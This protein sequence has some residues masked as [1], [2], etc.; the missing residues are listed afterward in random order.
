MVRSRA[1]ILG[2]RPG[3]FTLR[4]RS[5]IGSVHAR[6]GTAVAVLLLVPVVVAAAFTSPKAGATSAPVKGAQCFT[7]DGTSENG[8]TRTGSNP[9]RFKFR[10]TPYVGVRWDRCGAL[11]IY[12]GGYSRIT[13]YNVKY[14]TAFPRQVERGPGKAQVFDVGN[15]HGYFMSRFEVAVQACNRGGALQ[16]SSCTRWSPTVGVPITIP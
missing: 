14:G 15:W 11:K 8:G 5:F 16:S 4:T 10:N 2:K 6:R 1:V 13:H 7:S 9:V 12:Y 3:R